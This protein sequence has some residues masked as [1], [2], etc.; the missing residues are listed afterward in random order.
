MAPPARAEAASG[1]EVESCLRSTS[2]L[3]RVWGVGGAVEVDR[4][5]TVDFLGGTPVT[6]RG[7]RPGG[8]CEAPAEAGVEPD[9]V[10]DF[11][12]RTGGPR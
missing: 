6:P 9:R 10:F 7:F 5:W 8:V 2:G 12:P 11:D 1:H 3:W 4:D